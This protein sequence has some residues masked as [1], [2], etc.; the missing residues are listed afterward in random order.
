MKKIM[1]I[2]LLII[3]FYTNI[4]LA[5]VATKSEILNYVG[6]EIEIDSNKIIPKDVLG[7]VVHPFII[8]GTTYLPV[9]AISEA[10]GK[11]VE[12][13]GETNS[14]YITNP[15]E[16]KEIE[17]FSGEIEKKIFKETKTL[18]YKD[19][20]IYIN[21]ELIEPKDANGKIVEPFIIEGTTY[22]PVRAV[23]EAFNKKVNWIDETKT[24]EIKSQ[25]A[26]INNVV[27]KV[28]DEILC[29]EVT[30][31]M[32]INNFNSYL[33]TEGL[34][35][36]EPYLN[37]RENANTTSSI[38]SQIPKDEKITINAITNSESNKWYRVT[39][40][41]VTGWVSAKYVNITSSTRLVM[42]IAN[43]KFKIDTKTKEINYDN[44]KSIRFG[45]QGNN[46]SR[47]VLD[48]NNISSFNVV[49]NTDKTIT[50]FALNENFKLPAT[51]KGENVFV[52]TNDDKLYLPNNGE[53]IGDTEIPSGDKEVESGDLL[54]ENNNSG[55]LD[56]KNNEDSNISDNSGDEIIENPND[57]LDNII[58]G[59]PTLDENVSD[60]VEEKDNPNEEIIENLSRVTSIKYSSST[61]KTRI[62]IDGD[63]EYSSFTLKNPDRV[64]VDIKGAKL[65]VDGPTEINPNNKNITSIRFSQNEDTIVRVVFDV[66]A[67]SDYSITEK[68]SELA[69][70]IEE[71]TYKNIDYINYGTYATLV[72]KDTDIDYFDTEK[73]S[74][75]K[76]YITYSS[77]KFKSGT[78]NI[79]VD[80]EWVEEIDIRS[81]KITI[82]GEDKTNYSI[83]QKGSDV[84]IT[85][86]EQETSDKIILI[87]A[88]HGG[89][90]PGACNGSIYE[91]V[92][93]LKIA[94]KLRDMLEETDGIEVRMSRDDDTYI[95]RNGRLEFVLENPDAD[96]LVSIHNNSLA[97]KNYQGS[98]VLFYNKPGE[99]EKYG[100]T[101]KEFATIVKNNLINELDTI[102]RGVVSRPDLLILEQNV[103]GAVSGMGQ[104][105]LPAILCEVIFISNDEEAARLQKDSFQQK[106]AQ[107]IYDGIIE[108]I[109]IM[110]NN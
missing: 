36:A 9:R 87:D 106:T 96:L 48:L 5:S 33:I 71:V 55:D 25:V 28:I 42:D 74:S 37:M 38:I 61:N 47:I 4:T 100:I 16:K 63:Y 52:A 46:I 70:E 50:Y 41:N 65:E 22:L 105:N 94:L 8:N 102:D 90:D 11:N 26:Q 60:N 44:I 32:A 54:C 110:D 92:Y 78:G 58:I 108:A 68:K 1:I 21:D 73:T 77:R 6:I 86:K 107:A 34:I 49:Q 84:V 2:M 40:G 91:K 19:I 31:D 72:L 81:S 14:V 109:S 45:D 85:M 20:S 97:N 64:V 104:S 35:N 69:V 57:E 24:V 101:S 23:A 67:K 79:E 17:T 76:Y 27:I 3:A 30:T 43:T 82:Y 12:W 80:D 88:G 51:I 66:N 7:N 29:A 98:M 83:K 10:L 53:N 93:N 103:T 99:D 18:T 13:E 56:Y 89:T 39:Y 15:N 62:K 75:N 59:D 95:D